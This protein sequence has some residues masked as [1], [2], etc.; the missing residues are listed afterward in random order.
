MIRLTLHW[1][2]FIEGLLGLRTV[3]AVSTQRTKSR[4]IIWVEKKLSQLCVDSR[5]A[6]SR[7]FAP[8][9]TS[10]SSLKD[11][12]ITEI[13]TFFTENGK[14][15]RTSLWMA[16]EAVHSLKKKK[17]KVR[18]CPFSSFRDLCV[19]IWVLSCGHSPLCLD[20][21]LKQHLQGM[22]S[23]HRFPNCGHGHLLE[24][25]LL[26]LWLH[27]SG[28]CLLKRGIKEEGLPPS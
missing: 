21:F 14:M 8:L 17:K 6:D 7:V 16:K 23:G 13:L 2:D 9:R 10:S 25:V 19:E 24:S 5:W 18:I 15:S 4:I 20:R 22:K 12:A 11:T 3:W 28:V 27:W 26:T 1:A